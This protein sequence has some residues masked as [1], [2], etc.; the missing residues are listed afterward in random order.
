MK[1]YAYISAYDFI[2]LSV[3]LINLE[4][5]NM[6]SC[7]IRDDRLVNL[8]GGSFVNHIY[9]PVFTRHVNHLSRCSTYFV[10]YRCW[11]LEYWL[12]YEEQAFIVWKW[13]I[14]AS[15]PEYKSSSCPN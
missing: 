15:L 1:G 6:D 8:A 4:S 9:L 14:K 7:R 11:C 10:I 5:L 3:D 12:V 13:T 2:L